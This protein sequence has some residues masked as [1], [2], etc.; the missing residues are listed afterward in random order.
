[1][2]P[3][4]EAVIARLYA[5]T[6]RVDPVARQAARDR[7]LAEDSGP[8]FY[9][10]MREAYLPVTPA[11]GALLHL[12]ARSIRAR[13]VV[14]Y[15][16]SFGISTLYLAAAL[17]HNGGGRLIGTEIEPPKAQR[18]RANLAEA[19]LD[20]LVEIREGDAAR[21]LAEN[22]PQSIDLLL[23]DGAKSEYLHLLRMLESR[24]RPGAL[25]VADN[26]DMGGA[27][28]FLDYARDERNG[29]VAAALLTEALGAHH[30]NEILMRS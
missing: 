17:R 23:L 15:G 30:G 12:L 18:A 21:T 16:S 25:V 22:P 8:G 6:L 1:L 27:S 10:A 26:S 4:A 2:N 11:L 13:T 24:L 29:Y 9:S 7:G 3:Q 5:E 28:P 14:E 19:G 20:D